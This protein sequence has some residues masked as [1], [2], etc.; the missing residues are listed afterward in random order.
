MTPDG[1]TALFETFG[2]SGA[3]DVVLYDTVT[4]QGAV[5]T[6][7]PDGSKD[8]VT[9]ISAN[10]VVSAE[11]GDGAV[12]VDGATWTEAGGWN[13]YPPKYTPGCPPDR[14][15]AFDI[16]ADGK[17]TTGLVWHGCANEAF[18][19]NDTGGA[20]TITVLQVLGDGN[21]GV[22]SNRGTVI[23]DDGK[24]IGG[25]A[26]N[27]GLDRSAAVWHENGTGL[28]LEPNRA[29]PNDA[30]SEVLSINADGSVMA[31]IAQPD[32]WTWTAA[33]GVKTMPR[34][35]TLDA[36]DKIFPNSMTGDGKQI[37]G[38]VQPGS[39]LSL[40][41]PF[42][43]IWTADKGMRSLTDLVRAAGFA[44]PDGVTLGD[45][46]GVSRDGTVLVGASYTV[47][48]NTGFPNYKTFVLRVAP[49]T[50]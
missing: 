21:G 50:F 17:I 34:P 48:A 27:K 41:K 2:S 35:G 5:K 12:A 46:L 26:A 13:V 44:L 29:S 20:G 37:F 38:G 40:T 45:V 31:G 6:S 11:Y 28:L 32:A 19:W 14:S 36:S 18:R 15:G 22:A 33:T 9:G 47:D 43:F 3:V 30:P 10:L 23:S 8:M 1:R 7:V 25:Y 49:G 42:A 24:V 16:S 39:D 4:H